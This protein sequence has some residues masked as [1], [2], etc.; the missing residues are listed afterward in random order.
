M[1][2]EKNRTEKMIHS[3]PCVCERENI[4]ERKQ[5]RGHKNGGEVGGKNINAPFTQQSISESEEGLWG[6]RIDE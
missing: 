3:T 6:R 5:M 4:L 1:E 2:R